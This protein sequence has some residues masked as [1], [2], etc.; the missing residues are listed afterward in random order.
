MITD[1][2][3]ILS[4]VAIIMDGNGRWA[5]SHNKIRSI[6]HRAG[7]ENVINIVEACSE[8]NIK[9]LTLY[10]FSTENW[11]RPEEEKKAL[12][13]LLKEFYK[14]EIKRL[15]SNN[16]LVKH[17]G[18]IN[19]FPKDTIAVIKETEKETSE[20]CKNPIL[21]VILAL[22]YGFRDELK[23]A[24]KNICY[25]AKNN[26]IDIESI[27]EN[28]IRNYLYTKNI[29]DPDLII[30][31]SGESRLSNFLMYQASYSE[32]YFTDILWPDFSKEDFKKAVE[33]YSNRNRRY[34]GL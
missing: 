29:P 11:K 8:L 27:D 26:K 6:G 3:K 20:K 2:S 10:A 19:A 18:D 5:K 32:L 12:F 1:E 33:E 21:T 23:N 14:K 28:F 13:K 7:S 4:H 30:R 22:N 9:Y 34:G 16:I 24:L 15:I 17:I 31:T 25:E